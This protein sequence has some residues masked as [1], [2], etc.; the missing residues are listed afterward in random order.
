MTLSHPR[1]WIPGG[2]GMLGTQLAARA[3]A[4]G[5]DVVATGREVDAADPAVVAAFVAQHR[6][7]LVINCAAWTAVDLA[8]TEQA[9]AHRANVILPAVVGAAAARVGA[10]VLHVS[11]DY[12][13]DGAPPAP[14][15]SLREDDPTGPVSVYGATKLEGE[16]AFVQATAGLGAVV[17]TSWLYGPGGRNFVTTMLKLMA[18]REE[19]RVVAD[20]RGRPTSTA[21]LAD[22][23]LRLIDADARGVF[24]VA[25]D[26]GP[27]GISWHDF[28]VAIR[29]GALARGWPIKAHTIQAIPT[30]A[31]PTPA[32]RPAWSVLDTTRYT[33]LTGHSLPAWEQTLGSYLDELA[34]V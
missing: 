22:A 6:P 3:I 14:E 30:S 10:R 11:T 5:H 18:D 19:L 21:T 9:A 17:R 7:T 20:Q 33:A 29:A 24:H 13:F 8:E 4:R 28:A 2:R 32:K 1:L 12:V 25:D 23:L 31:W 26:A 27:R 15:R 16:R 34:R